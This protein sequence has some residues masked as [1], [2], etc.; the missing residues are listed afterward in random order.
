MGINN[1]PRRFLATHLLYTYFMALNTVDS[2]PAAE[3]HPNPDSIPEKITEGD[4]RPVRLGPG[5]TQIILQ[6]H[7]AYIRDQKDPRK[8]S[9]TEDAKTAAVLTASEYFEGLLHRLTPA[10]RE[11]VDV[12]VV[13]S[14][15]QYFGGGRRS[16]ETAEAAQQAVHNVFGAHELS[17][18]QILPTPGEGRDPN[19]PWPMPNLRDPQ[20]LTQSPAFAEFLRQNYGDAT[21]FWKAFEEDVHREERLQHG[22]EGPDDIV[23]RT[24]VS[25]RQLSAYA[26]SY[27]R[28]NPGRRLVIWAATHY[29]TISPLVRRDILGLSDWKTRYLGVNYGA[30]IS[31]TLDKT[32]THATARVGGKTYNVPRSLISRPNS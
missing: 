20:F 21:E 18:S 2:H 17:Q 8:G 22:A 28:A 30:G 12:L 23:A 1:G 11:T 14:D 5:E 4:I 24:E 13:A 19:Q 6:R 26:R 16:Y 9:L 32:G 3:H 29:D 27:H 10:E 31:I 25:V 15:S 7:G